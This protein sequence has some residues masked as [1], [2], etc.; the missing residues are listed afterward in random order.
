MEEFDW[1]KRREEPAD[2]VAHLHCERLSFPSVAGPAAHPENMGFA[3]SEAFCHKCDISIDVS[4]L[5]AKTSSFG[6]I[7]NLGTMI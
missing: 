7:T 6:V 2:L 1:S 3:V 4:L 5:Q